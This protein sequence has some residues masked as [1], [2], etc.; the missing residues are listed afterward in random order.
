MGR[1]F[2]CLW[3]RHNCRSQVIDL[4]LSVLISWFIKSIIGFFN[5][6]NLH[7]IISTPLIINLQWVQKNYFA[8]LDELITNAVPDWSVV[9]ISCNHSITRLISFTKDA[10]NQRSILSVYGPW[11]G[12]TGYLYLSWMSTSCAR[13]C[14][15]S[16]IIIRM[17]T[18]P[19][20]AMDSSIRFFEHSSIISAVVRYKQWSL[21]NP[22]KSSSRPD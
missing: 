17:L 19:R 16:R 2:V 6:S 3:R 20:P 7:A 8:L 10:S 11:V 21:G 5:N 18:R 12:I 15:D 9:F 14:L 22:P 4:S 13:R 1:N